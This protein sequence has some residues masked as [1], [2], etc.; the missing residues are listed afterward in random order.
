[1][2][3][4]ATVSDAAKPGHLSNPRP[5]SEQ[6]AFLQRSYPLVWQRL[7]VERVGDGNHSLLLT[8]AG[9]EPSLPPALFISHLDVV[10]VTPGT[11]GDWRHPPFSGAV[12][13]GF[14]WGACARMCVRQQW[15][16]GCRRGIFACQ[17]P[18]SDPPLTRCHPTSFR[19]N[20]TTHTHTHTVLH[21]ADWDTGRGALDV[22]NGVAGLLESAAAL[23]QEGYVPRRTLLLAF[24]QD[25]EVGGDAGAGSIAGGCS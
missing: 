4:F 24:G 18:G 7:R 23:L 5:F 17:P 16:W 15:G 2:L 3:T 10:P 20:A 13:E 19:P 14:I 22:K 25:E 12:A 21:C 11:E 1:M 9:G 6:L 8:W